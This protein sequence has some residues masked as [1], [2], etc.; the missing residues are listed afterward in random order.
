MSSSRGNAECAG[1]TESVHANIPMLRA[2]AAM[3]MPGMRHARSLLDTAIC[4]LEY[5]EKDAVRDASG[6]R[7]TSQTRADPAL[8]DEAERMVAM[9]SAFRRLA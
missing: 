6:G 4:V 5:F 3:L 7:V 9:L 1:T 8:A 2:Q